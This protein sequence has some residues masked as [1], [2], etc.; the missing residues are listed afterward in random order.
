MYSRPYKVK[1]H[2]VFFLTI[3][4]SL[5]VLNPSKDENDEVFLVFEEEEDAT[6]AD[7]GVE[8]TTGRVRDWS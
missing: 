3:E 5:G 2:V 1:I 7:G 6:A 8:S 4:S